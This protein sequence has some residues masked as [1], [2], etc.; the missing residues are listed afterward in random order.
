MDYLDAPGGGVPPQSYLGWSWS[1]DNM[2]SLI[3]DYTGTPQCDGATFKAH[4]L[5]Q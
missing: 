1:T 4:L 5:A 3:S 2:P